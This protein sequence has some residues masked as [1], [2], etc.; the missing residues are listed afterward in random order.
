M[1]KILLVLGLAV[2]VTA[3]SRSDG[4]EIPAGSEVTL[5]Q[6]DGVSVAGRLVEVQSEHVVLEGV[7][8]VQRK[9]PRAN[10]A[11]LRAVP[12]A[13]NREARSR[14]VGDE[15][16]Q[17]PNVREVA[18][19]TGETPGDDDRRDGDADATRESRDSAERRNRDTAA[20]YREVTLPAGTVL[21]LT[22]RTTVGSDVS[23]VEDPVRATLR[24]AVVINGVQALPAGTVVTGHVTNAKRSARVKGRGEVGFRFT[25]LD[26]PGEGGLMNVR[27]GTVS[28][29]APGTKKRDAAT[30]GGGA[31]GGAIVGGLLGG[32]DGAAKGAAAGGA[33]GT[34]VVLA[35]RGK[36]I[37]LAAGTPVNV[38]LTAPLT[39]RVPR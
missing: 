18:A 26:L 21:P 8:G 19:T 15:R 6:R 35:T 17:D 10:I 9:V 7:D 25:R 27:T 37:R 13:E 14:T 38:R 11:Q 28:R 39:V 30:I 32:G 23:R 29:V 3:C 16:P 12:V 2:A 36:D 24:R 1:R 31:V 4:F 33:A 20:E 5:Q 34:G 22:L